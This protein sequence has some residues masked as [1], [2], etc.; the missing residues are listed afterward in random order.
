MHVSPFMPM[1]VDY[2]WRFLSPADVLTVH[3]EN[4][5]GG[6]KLFDATLVL[7]RREITPRALARVLVAFPLMTLKVIAALHWQALK[8]WL[9]GSPVYEHPAKTAA[10]RPVPGTFVSGSDEGASPPAMLE[11]SP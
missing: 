5:R 4:S 1:D 7:Q 9:K 6:R 2:D 3:M 11:R 10:R 8:L